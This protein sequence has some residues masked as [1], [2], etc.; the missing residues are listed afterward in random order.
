MV[1]GTHSLGAHGTPSAMLSLDGFLP[2]LADL[3]PVDCKQPLLC[4]LQYQLFEVPP[5][6][7]WADDVQFGCA[8]AMTLSLGCTG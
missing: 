8:A 1:L 6:Q 7:M 3:K 4:V 2:C 5:Q